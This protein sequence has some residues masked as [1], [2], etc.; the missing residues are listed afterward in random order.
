MK[1]PSIWWELAIY[2]KK[3]QYKFTKV[4]LSLLWCKGKWLH[5]PFT[6]TPN[7]HGQTNFNY[8]CNRIGYAHKGMA[9][10]I[11]RY[12]HTWE[13]YLV[14]FKSTSPFEAGRS[15]NVNFFVIYQTLEWLCVIAQQNQVYVAHTH[16][17]RSMLFC[18]LKLK[19]WSKYL[20]Y[21]VKTSTSTV[22][23]RV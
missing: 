23:E 9:S 15:G 6:I 8:W 18:K 16:P 2:K 22:D 17:P 12:F 10:I 4:S 21:K 11:F 7:F 19:Y 14:N 20:I 1:F 3:Y 5:K 13:T